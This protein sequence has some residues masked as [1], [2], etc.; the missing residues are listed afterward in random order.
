MRKAHSCPG[1]RRPGQDVIWRGEVESLVC[2]GPGRYR[3]RGNAATFCCQM[4]A[5]SRLDA[6]LT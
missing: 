2:K 3:Q 1:I 5:E 4:R 6:L